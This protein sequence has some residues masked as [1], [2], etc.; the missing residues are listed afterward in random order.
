MLGSWPLHSIFN[1]RKYIVIVGLTD[2]LDKYMYM[3]FLYFK[4]YSLSCESDA[5][6]SR[7]NQTERVIILTEIRCIRLMRIGEYHQNVMFSHRSYNHI[8]ICVQ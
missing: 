8:I 2:W 6:T 4:R 7:A 3:H 1:L 5:T